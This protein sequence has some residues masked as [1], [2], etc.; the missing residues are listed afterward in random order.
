V[1]LGLDAFELTALAALS[2][3]SVAVLVPLL[4]RGRPL[5]GADG[6]Y[7]IDQLQYF[8]WIREAAHHTLIGNR[9]DLAPGDR[10]FLHPGFLLSALAHRLTGFSIPLSYLLWKPAAVLLTFCGTLA[11]VRRLLGSTGQRRAALVICLF[12][13][14]PASALVAWTAWGGGPRI[15]TFDFISGEMWTGQYLWGYLMTALAVFSMPF[16]LLLAERWR[17]SRRPGLLVLATA[18]TLLVTWLQPWQ[19][20]TLALIVVAVEAWRW[21]SE[22]E[23]PAAALAWIPVAAGTAAAYYAALGNLDPSWEMAGKANAAGSQ[24]GW[25]WPWWAIA[26][27]VAPLAIP[28]AL[29]YRPARD[30]PWDWQERALRVW[31]LAALLVLLL[32]VTFPYHAFQGIQIPLAILAVLGLRG[33]RL[34]PA[35]VVA[36][37]ALLVVPGTA[38]KLQIAADNIHRGTDPF[39]ILGDERRALD[40]LGAERLPG[41]VLSPPGAGA[42]IPYTTGR[43]S[44]VGTLS[45]TPHFLDRSY[46]ATDL[47]AGTLDPRR[48]RAFV[49]GSRARFVYAPCGTAAGRL[50]E[51]PLRDLVQ[52]VRRFGCATVYVL[53]P[54]PEQ[55]AA[56]GLP[57]A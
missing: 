44:Y 42:Y 34:S 4:T 26:L 51:D 9:F 24:P 22:R 3:L 16:V 37:L 31:P 27:T 18:L 53:R 39:Y 19:G 10:P 52:S 2:L 49:L 55:A 32:P 1:L 17:S 56:A 23:R 14:M 21:R 57:D 5:S 36:A 40:W 41:G 28:A 30:R 45:W 7:P 6:I 38:H 15:Y 25:S 12:A 11:Y 47:F 29:A 43:E 48:A 13:V 20:A 50:L 33:V 46:R 54:R 8:A 35:A